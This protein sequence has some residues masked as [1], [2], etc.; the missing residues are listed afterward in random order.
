[1]FTLWSRKK[2]KKVYRANMLLGILFNVLQIQRHKNIKKKYK[3]PV[4]SVFIFFSDQ[5]NMPIAREKNDKNH[6]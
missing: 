5:S 2:K 3:K 1:M 6:F 4:L